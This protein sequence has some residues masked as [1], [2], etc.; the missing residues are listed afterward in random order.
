MT[1]LQSHNYIE[2]KRSALVIFKPLQDNEY[3]ER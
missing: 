2:V 1:R 3:K